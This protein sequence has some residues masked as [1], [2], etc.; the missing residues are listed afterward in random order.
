MSQESSDEEESLNVLSVQSESKT[1]ADDEEDQPSQLSEEEKKVKKKKAKK[2]KIGSKASGEGGKKLKTKLLKGLDK[3]NLLNKFDSSKSSKS[4][5]ASKKKSV[6][7]KQVRAQ[8]N[9]KK[10][11]EKA[12]EPSIKNIKVEKNVEP[13]AETQVAETKPIPIDKSKLRYS[14]TNLAK[15][16]QRPQ[17]YDRKAEESISNILN[18]KPKPPSKTTSFTTK[19]YIDRSAAIIEADQTIKFKDQKAVTSQRISPEKMTKSLNVIVKHL[20]KNKK[21]LDRQPSSQ[22]SK[23]TIKISLSSFI[24]EDGERFD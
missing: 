23:S 9:L 21:S 22:E 12:K 24:N 13:K 19:S 6:P 18:R 2:S 14:Q 17:L 1:N 4:V 7:E 8:E 11:K 5:N 10:P 3:V 16:I 20:F 15:S